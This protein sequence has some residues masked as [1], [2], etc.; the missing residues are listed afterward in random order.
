[1]VPELSYLPIQVSAEHLDVKTC[2]CNSGKDCTYIVLASRPIGKSE[3]CAPH[4]V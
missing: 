2:P 4:Q 3:V 1:M